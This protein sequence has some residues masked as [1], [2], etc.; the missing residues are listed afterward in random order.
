[1]TKQDK[2]R[3]N[4][5]ITVSRFDNKLTFAFAGVGQFTFDP[6]KVSTENR[7]RAMIHGFEQRIR[8]A[9][10]LSV[11]RDTGKSASAEAK[12]DAAKRIVDHLM[13]GAT[14]WN[15]KPAA[16]QGVDAGLTILAMIRAFT[17]TI[18]GVRM[19][20][21]KEWHADLDPV[22]EVESTIAATMAKRGIDRTAALK[23][24]AASKQVAQAILDIKRERLNG[25]EDSDDLLA[26]MMGDDSGG[27][28][29]ETDEDS[30][31]GDEDAPM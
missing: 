23:L 15:L 18:D 21:G 6:D 2:K 30:D 25:Q 1:M 3:V 28:D 27:E 14:D 13:S 26:E 9:A 19:I 24:W 5:I 22:A 12:F 20:L 10:A 4:S 7:A 16:P 11:D 17:K 8:D 31:E 29:D